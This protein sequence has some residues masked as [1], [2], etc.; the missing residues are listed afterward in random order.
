LLTPVHPFAPLSLAT[1]R[2][3]GEQPE[4]IAKLQRY[5]C[6]FDM[7]GHPTTTLPGGFSAEGLPVGFQLVAAELA[8]ATLIRA[9]A[10]FQGVTSW[11]RRR[12]IA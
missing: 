2:T 12:P 11:H 6:P 8:E 7:S 5:T 4:L 1:V 3:L 10:A 9:G